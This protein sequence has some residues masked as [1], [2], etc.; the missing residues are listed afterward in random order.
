MAG[1]QLDAEQGT[2]VRPRPAGRPSGLVGDGDRP[3]YTPLG[4][5]GHP[6]ILLSSLVSATLPASLQEGSPLQ[7][8]CGNDPSVACPPRVAGTSTHAGGCAQRV[9]V[10]RGVTRCGAA[11]R[12]CR[13]M[14]E[15]PAALSRRVGPALCLCRRI[16]W[17]SRSSGEP[18][19]V[20]KCRRPRSIAES[21]RRLLQ[22]GVE[23]TAGLVHPAHVELVT[24]IARANHH[25][26]DV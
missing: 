3:L 21:G 20:V 26:Q 16:G 17:F 1:I 5:R 7:S 24:L 15:A 23:C 8:L 4:G 11:F 12:S 2:R 10:P 6:L 9:T 25:V 18:L 13:G 14:G 19:C 22:R